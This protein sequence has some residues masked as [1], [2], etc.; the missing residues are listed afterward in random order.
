MKKIKQGC[1]SVWG[2]GFDRGG[3]RGRHPGRPLR[4]MTVMISR[5]FPRVL[6]EKH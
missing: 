6:K 2:N 5:F 1:D 3:G 4:V